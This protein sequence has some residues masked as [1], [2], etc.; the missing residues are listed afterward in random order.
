VKEGVNAEEA[1]MDL[2]A[3]ITDAAITVPGSLDPVTVL[4]RLKSG[5][6]PLELFP[7]SAARRYPVQPDGSVADVR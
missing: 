4:G 6:R 2:R 5:N 7:R 1:K 3:G